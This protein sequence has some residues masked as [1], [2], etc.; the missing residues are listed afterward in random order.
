MIPPLLNEISPQKSG[1]CE[2][3]MREMDLFANEHYK[4]GHL[5][6][7]SS[8][9]CMKRKKKKV[10]R[11]FGHCSSSHGT[12]FQID[13][14]GIKSRITSTNLEMSLVWV[15]HHCFFLLQN[16]EENFT[17]S[18]RKEFRKQLFNVV[19]IVQ[20]GKKELQKDYEKDYYPQLL[21]KNLI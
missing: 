20:I 21:L 4:R 6:I 10:S 19:K 16:G 11:K 12:N 5:D 8:L 9:N 3:H 18:K 1:F 13:F 7:F 2:T 17:E 14:F 15:L